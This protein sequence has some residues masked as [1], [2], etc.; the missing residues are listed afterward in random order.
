MILPF[1]CFLWYV[2]I[3]LI[4]NPRLWCMEIVK[5]IELKLYNGLQTTVELPPPLQEPM[6]Y[7]SLNSQAFSQSDDISRMAEPSCTQMGSSKMLKLL[8]RSRDE[9]QG[10]LCTLS[11]SGEE[12]MDLIQSVENLLREMEDLHI[13]SKFSR[14]TM[15]LNKQTGCRSLDFGS[16]HDMCV[17]KMNKSLQPAFLKRSAVSTAYKC[18]QKMVIQ[19]KLDSPT[20]KLRE[21]DKSI[22]SLLRHSSSFHSEVHG[23]SDFDA[24]AI[25]L[26]T[27]SDLN[28]IKDANLRNQALALAKEYDKPESHRVLNGTYTRLDEMRQDIM[29]SRI[30]IIPKFDKELEIDLH[31]WARLCTRAM[32]SLVRSNYNY[33]KK[34]VSFDQKILAHFK[35]LSNVMHMRG[36]PPGLASGEKILVDKLYDQL[37]DP[38]SEPLLEGVEA[39]LYHACAANG[40][41]GGAKDE[42]T[43][44]SFSTEAL[45]LQDDIKNSDTFQKGKKLFKLALETFNNHGKAEFIYSCLTSVQKNLSMSDQ[46]N[47]TSKNL[48]ALSHILGSRCDNDPWTL[49]KALWLISA[50]E[51]SISYDASWQ[52]TLHS[53]LSKLRENLGRT[54]GVE[55]Q[56]DKDL[57]DLLVDESVPVYMKILKVDKYLARCFWEAIHTTNVEDIS[58]QPDLFVDSSYQISLTHFE[59][60]QQRTSQINQLA[61]LHGISPKKSQ[62]R[63]EKLKN[64][65]SKEVYKILPK[66]RLDD[67]ELSMNKFRILEF[68]GHLSPPAEKLFKVLV[69]KEH[70][71]S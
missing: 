47:F 11:R 30:T 37:C 65:L 53:V 27:K 22:L 38:N 8:R 45:R 3:G 59:F 63:L 50:V 23:P 6:S 18:M 46:M 48:N 70:V 19:D 1:Y 14:P 71:Q 29:K 62:Q 28:R 4:L 5:H 55:K 64:S 56:R 21:V 52:E 32:K 58:N 35:K 40:N 25:E 16:I 17:M 20:T 60:L 13:R 42:N 36:C 43:E 54:E 68:D 7:E 10:A 15:D 51:D 69:T 66:F 9:L 24:L 49:S 39:L 12:E 44:K 57:L 67:Q 41:F 33:E 31:F 34:S 2:V 61:N 26:S